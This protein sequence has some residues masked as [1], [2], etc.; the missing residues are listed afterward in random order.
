MTQI[1]I[2]EQEYNQIAQRRKTARTKLKALEKERAKAEKALKKIDEKIQKFVLFADDSKFDE[3]V[4]ALRAQKAMQNKE[5]NQ[6][7]A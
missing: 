5:S 3:Q 6:H 2:T 7:N 4:K 1:T